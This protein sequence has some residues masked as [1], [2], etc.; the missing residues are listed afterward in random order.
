[1]IFF[2]S[3]QSELSHLYQP[4]APYT[5]ILLGTKKKNPWQPPFTK[6][7]NASINKIV[8]TLHLYYVAGGHKM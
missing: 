1:M 8:D 2:N 3:L 7:G 4:G 5:V 6:Q